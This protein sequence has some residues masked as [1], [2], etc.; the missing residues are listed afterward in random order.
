MGDGGL[1]VVAVGGEGV[2]I[3]AVA[4]DALHGFHIIDTR[5]LTLNPSTLLSKQVHTL[6]TG[7]HNE[8][9][10]VLISKS[11]QIILINF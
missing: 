2:S 9:K 11:K 6:S 10:F 5:H 4:V 3:L 8:F 1:L 7:S